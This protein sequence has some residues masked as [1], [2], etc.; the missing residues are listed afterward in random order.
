[1]VIYSIDDL[2]LTWYYST[3]VFRKYNIPCIN[4]RRWLES[5]YQLPIIADYKEWE[6]KSVFIPFCREALA[7]YWSKLF[8]F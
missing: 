4:S 2:N 7:T 6:I 5:F 3:I 8:L 1:M